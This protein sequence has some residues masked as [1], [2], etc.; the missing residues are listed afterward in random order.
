MSKNKDTAMVT[1]IVRFS[2]PHVFEPQAPQDGDGK[3]KYSISLIIPK[4][5]KKTIAKVKNCI[6]AAAEAG[7]AKLG[8][9]IP[10]NLK[11]PLRDGDIDKEDDEAYKDSYFLSA[12]SYRRPQIVEKVGGELV[13][14]MDQNDFYAGCYGR[15]SLNFFAFNVGVNKGIAAGLNNLMKVKDG[16]QLGGVT[17]AEDDFADF[18]DND[19]DE[20]DDI[21]DDDDDLLD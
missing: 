18:A 7:K 3:P 6:Q 5:D 1:E 17:S 9:K 21:E 13:E 14:L 20:F 4:S 12:S 11:T 15:A 8:G 19:V 16:E 2:Y 10:K